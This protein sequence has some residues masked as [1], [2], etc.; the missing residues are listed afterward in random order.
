MMG[1]I[2]EATCAQLEASVAEQAAGDCEDCAGFRVSFTGG[3]WAKA[4]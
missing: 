4:E 2:L 1:R 3:N